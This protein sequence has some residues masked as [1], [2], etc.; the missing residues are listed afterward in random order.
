M[1]IELLYVVIPLVGYLLLLAT[2]RGLARRRTRRLATSEQNELAALDGEVVDDERLVVLRGV[3]AAEQADP[4][5]EDDDG[6][7]H[8]EAALSHWT[9]SDPLS[10]HQDLEVRGAGQEVNAAGRLFVAH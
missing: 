2:V 9:T 1:P 5:S 7:T 3:L 6:Q 10:L 4:A 8:T